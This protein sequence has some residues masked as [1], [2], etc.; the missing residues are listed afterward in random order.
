MP[1]KKTVEQEMAE[2]L[3]EWDFKQLSN[4]LRDIIPL[5]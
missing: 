1:R 4:F 5:F 3:E 2:F